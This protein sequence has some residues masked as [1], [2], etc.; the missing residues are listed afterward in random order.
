MVD[1]RPISYRSHAVSCTL[2]TLPVV[3]GDEDKQEVSFSPESQ[4]AVS[5][6][7][8]VT[9]PGPLYQRALSP[10]PLDPGTWKC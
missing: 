6:L 3:G 8:S 7:G 9:G 1:H 2:P 5:A 4:L 10:A